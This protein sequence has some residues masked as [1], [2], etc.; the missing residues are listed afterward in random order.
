M[1][2]KTKGKL[3]SRKEALQ[4]FSSLSASRDRFPLRVSIARNK[5]SISAYTQLIRLIKAHPVLRREIFNQEFPA[6]TEQMR[7]VP[8]LAASTPE[9]EIRWSGAH[10]AVHVDKLEK[11]NALADRFQRAVLLNDYFDAE[12]TLERIEAE[13]GYSLWFIKNK[14]AF[15]QLSAGL[16]AQKQFVNQVRAASDSITALITYYVSIRNEPAVTPERFLFRLEQDLWRVELPAGLETYLRHHIYPDINVSAEEIADILRF[17]GAGS[18]LDRYETFIRAAQLAVCNLHTHLFPALVATLEPLAKW[19]NDKRIAFLLLQLKDSENQFDFL[20]PNAINIFD[21]Y[22]RGEYEQACRQSNDLLFAEECNNYDLM[23]IAAISMAMLGEQPNFVQKSLVTKIISRMSS[24]IIKGDT[25]HHDFDYLLKIVLNFN[26]FPWALGIWGFIWR[27]LASKVQESSDYFQRFTATATATAMPLRVNAFAEVPFKAKFAN[28]IQNSYRGSLSANFAAT[29]AGNNHVTDLPPE[30]VPDER[31]LLIAETAWRLRDYSETLRAAEELCNSKQTFYRQR[32]I[33]FKL[34]C[35][36]EMN[37]IADCV[38][39]ITS[40]FVEQP[41]WWYILPFKETIEAVDE[42]WH[43]RLSSDISLPILYDLYSKFVNSDKD[44]L[45]NYAYEDFL[46]ANQIERPSE[47]KSIAERF[48][49]EKIVYFMRYISIEFVMSGST[50]FNGSREIAEERLKV[51]RLLLDFDKESSEVYQDEIKDTLRQ[52]MIHRR[53]REIEQSRIY[54]DI[55]GIKRKV[56]KTMKENFLRYLSFL[57]NKVN[58]EIVQEAK[59]LVKLAN[60][61]DFDRLLNH[62]LPNNEMKDIFERMIVELRDEFVSSSVHGLDLY[63]SVRIRHG[64]LEGQLRK[65]LEEANLITELDAAAGVYKPNT[66]WLEL[67]EIEDNGLRKRLTD[68]FGEFSKQFDA[69]VQKVK[70]DWIQ[71]KKDSSGKGFFDFTLHEP[72]ITIYTASVNEETKFEQFLDN[73]FAELFSILELSLEKVRRAIN[74]EFKS[75]VN[76]L[77]TVLQTEIEKVGYYVDASDLSNTIISTR[78]QIQNVINGVTE[79]FQLS[80]TTANEPLLLMDAISIGEESVRTALHNFDVEVLIESEQDLYFEG[81]RLISFVDILFIIFENMVKHSGID[82]P[83]AVINVDI[84]E[85]SVKIHIENNVAGGV[86]TKSR[87]KIEAI[88]KAMGA[89]EHLKSVTSEGGTGFHK[90]GKI[91]DHD[92]ERAADLDFGFADDERFFVEFTL[93]AKQVQGEEDFE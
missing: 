12:Q 87:K 20:N 92:F 3:K 77:L 37:K 66:F 8:V 73:V 23:E 38:S 72:Q 62:V 13:F 54:V 41:N 89:N 63:L 26:S 34:H 27:E 44:K 14:I 29:V 55:D 6:D 49:L 50:V 58:S 90:I 53:M 79:W 17:E 80:K 81:N 7:T 57:K 91:L 21:L 22:L 65:P 10:L 9:R 45:R 61:G 24:M 84:G 67:L 11:F 36:L 48:D 59:E 51:C 46:F 33:R 71:V 60:A 69:L 28:V 88:K 16:D 39:F 42:N 82:H 18:V 47:I 25:F 76:N 86:A 83:K 40:V 30:L 2:K 15:L 85:T 56:E 68:A 31:N 19:V 4:I 32:G 35:L 5:S 75:G 74:N 1:P 43:E 64:T 70:N 78:T 52:L 93:P